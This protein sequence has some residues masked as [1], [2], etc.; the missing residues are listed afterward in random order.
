MPRDP[1]TVARELDAAIDNVSAAIHY[2][3]PPTPEVIDLLH[4]CGSLIREL[5]RAM[6]RRV[7]PIHRTEESDNA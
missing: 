1:Y 2:G 4:Q 6:V 7:E 3:Y 5:R